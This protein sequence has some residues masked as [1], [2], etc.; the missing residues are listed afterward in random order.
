[1][2]DDFLVS[3]LPFWIVTY[4]L[5][6]MGWSCI[7]RFMMQFVVAPDSTNYIWRAFRALSAGPVA[8]AR[9]MVP[10][11]V[12]PFFLPLVAAFWVFILRMGF[13]LAMLS[14]GLAPR[15]SPAGG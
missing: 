5:A 7:G 12:G 14:A 13:G 8:V 2:G 9:L 11:Y 3:Y 10:S 1:M 6:V 15:V 4:A